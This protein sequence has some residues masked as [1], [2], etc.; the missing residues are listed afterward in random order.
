MQA[1]L[2][3]SLTLALFALPLLPALSEWRRKSDAQP[4][5]V[6]RDHGGSATT[7]AERFRDVAARQFA[8]RLEQL[9]D[10]EQLSDRMA[11]GC[12]YLMLGRA[13]ALPLRPPERSAR[14]VARVIAARGDLH[15]PGRTLFESEIYAGGSVSS[16]AGSALRAALARG[17]IVLAEGCWVLRWAHADGELHIGP[18]CKCYGR[19]T[20]NRRIQ[21]GRG[22]EFARLSAPVV[23]F[24]AR[25]DCAGAPAPAPALR[26]APLA[27]PPNLRDRRGGRW[28]IDG[29]LQIPA[30]RLHRGDIVSTGSLSVQ[31]GSCV[32]GSLKSNAALRL[33]AGVRIEGAVVAAG[34]LFI[35][36]GCQ[37]TGPVVSEQEVH[38]GSGT[39]VGRLDRPSSISAPRLR[40]EASVRVHGSIWVREWGE[41]IC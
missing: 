36:S 10:G 1:F 30:G 11:D 17:D 28:L 21:V 13:A 18:S 20:S 31:T 40:V 23:D 4:L 33:E 14:I 3:V 41:A 15:L 6:A 2:F 34:P 12:E 9:P 25:S 19:I 27:A 8:P 37:V 5:N 24:E 32:L 38:L 26:R 39:T 22:S 7:F 29:D 16:A 35:G